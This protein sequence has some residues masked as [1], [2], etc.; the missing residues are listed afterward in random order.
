MDKMLKKIVGCFLN[1][2]IMLACFSLVACDNDRYKERYDLEDCSIQSIGV[3]YNKKFVNDEFN[4]YFSFSDMDAQIT[5]NW[6]DNFFDFAT[7]LKENQFARQLTYYVGEA[8]TVKTWS[9]D[10]DGVVL[11]FPK[12]M[13]TDEAFAWVLYEIF[14]NDELPYGVYAG[15]AA[16]WLNLTNDKYDIVNYS[17]IEGADYLTELQFPIYETDNLPEDEKSF[18]WN[19]SFTL[20]KDWLKQGKTTNELVQLTKLDLNLYLQTNYNVTLP[21]Y[22]FMPDSSSYEYK[23]EQGIYTYYINKQFRDAILPE[24]VFSMTYN[25][26]SSWLKDNWAMKEDSD[27]TFGV[28]NMYDINVYVDDGKDSVISGY[29]SSGARNYINIYSV[30]AFSHEY[31]HHILYYK[32][33]SGYLSEVLPELQAN[34]SKYSNLMW[35]HLFSGNSPYVYSEKDN[36]KKTYEQAMELYNKRSP[37]AA[38][39]GNFNFW[40]FADCFSAIHTKKGTAF[41]SRL[42]PDSLTY[43]IA[44]EYGTE[45]IWE[46]NVD[47]SEDVMIGDKTYLEVL[48]IEWFSYLEE[49]YK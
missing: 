14:G 19:F 12:K 41:I 16:Y 5:D 36:E 17:Q 23:V 37:Y 35:Y 7:L 26:L 45:Y 49:L 28:Y 2:C 47:N 6:I 43:F 29:A 33:D 32:G 8:N 39:A 22:S 15:I 40:L 1:L 48:E 27:E 11:Q 24:N 31:I 25:H 18:A 42:Q 38:T 9:N 13:E 34:N 21:N 44:K 30:G 3:E 20:V 10:N 4:A 46:I